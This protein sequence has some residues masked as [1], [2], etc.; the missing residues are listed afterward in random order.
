MGEKAVSGLVQQ[1]YPAPFN[2]VPPPVTTHKPG[3]LPYSEIRKF[4]EEVS[5]LCSSVVVFVSCMYL[6]INDCLFT[7]ILAVF[8]SC[9]C[10]I[11][12]C[13]CDRRECVVGTVKHSW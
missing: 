3:Q 6:F 4:F 11:T 1:A 10:N 7:P 9:C 2:S 8:C 12:F 5:S 13:V